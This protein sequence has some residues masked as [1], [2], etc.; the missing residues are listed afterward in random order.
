MIT[1]AFTC[2]GPY[3]VLIMLG[4]KRVENRGMMPMPAKGRCA[5]SCSKSFSKEEYGDFVHWASRAL[6][7]EDFERIPAWGDVKDWAGKIVGA[8]D[9]EARGRNDLRLEGEEA[10][11]LHPTNAAVAGRPPCQW[12][13]GYAYWWDLSE[14]VSF[15]EPIP[16]RGNVG[17]WQMPDALAAKVMRADAR[18]RSIGVKVST[19]ADAVHVFREAI[20]IAGEREGFFVLPLDASRRTLSA[21]ILVSLGA[22]HGT[23]AV[24]AGE[25]FR[26]AL[27]VGAEAMIVAHN[28]PSGDLR[29]SVADRT[30]TKMLEELSTLMNVRLID[31]LIEGAATFKDNANPTFVSLHEFVEGSARL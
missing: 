15:D 12:D 19:T 1:S 6:P 21:P 16:C 7:L 9:Y 25:V 5:V 18:A 30:L 22:D 13:E 3:A 8:C 31:H 4:I 17:M 23:A 20:P 24:D 26:E 27:K 29:P 10:R 2:T 11:R 14:V 28:H